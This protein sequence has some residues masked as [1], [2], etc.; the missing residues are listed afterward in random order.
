MLDFIVVSLPRSAS[1]WLA[2]FLTTDRSLCLH[3]PF[4]LG[5]PDTWPRDNRVR[6][7]ACTGAYLLG[8]WMEQFSCP[9][10]V[11]ERDPADCERSLH[12]VG[13]SVGCDDLARELKLVPGYRIAFDDLWNEDAARA[14]WAHLLPDAPFDVIRYRLLRDMQ[15]QPHMGKIVYDPTTLR[16]CANLLRAA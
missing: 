8:K 9:V 3:D 11:I 14:L 13:M 16:T 4:A 15:V 6:G 5:M 2:N 12:A 1:T 10:A 7:I